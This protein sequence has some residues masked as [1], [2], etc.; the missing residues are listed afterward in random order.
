[1]G[2]LPA[3][4]FSLLGLTAQGWACPWALPVPPAKEQDLGVQAMPYSVCVLYLSFVCVLYLSFDALPKT[5][6]CRR[7][8]QVEEGVCSSD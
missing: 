4:C 2:L 6:G 1:M 3:L 8:A 5:F 7:L